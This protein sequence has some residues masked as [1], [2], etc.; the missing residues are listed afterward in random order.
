MAEKMKIITDINKIVPRLGG[1][2]E[3][4]G[5][6]AEHHLYLYLY[7][8]GE[9][10]DLV[11][12]D[13][14]K[15]GGIATY[16]KGQQWYIADEP[17]APF[18]KQMP[19]FVEVL[20]HICEQVPGV[21][22]EDWT[23]NLIKECKNAL[24]PL[25]YHMSRPSSVQYC[26]IVNLEKFDTSFSGK[27]YKGHRYARNHFSKNYTVEFKDASKIPRD[28]L[29]KLIETWSRKRTAQDKVW[30]PDYIKF[31]KNDFP[32]CDIKR[33]LF[34]DGILRGL[35][36]GWRIPNSKGYYIYMDI[37]DYSDAYLGEFV[38]IDHIIEAKMLGYK[39]L[40]FGGSDKNLLH[41][42]KKFHPEAVYTMCNFSVRKIKSG[43]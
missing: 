9:E 33:A 27:K 12:F 22:V 29:I 10:Y 20:K 5:H 25:P 23:E 38:S 28:S 2:I 30:G 37:H 15:D 43:L 11:Y 21:F 32:G 34:L 36:V 1:H 16:K 6:T 42:K 40:D 14:G 26:P 4:F 7:S 19:L 35:S 41:F 8:I 3:K 24:A 13:F 31:I 39:Y 18:Q 17:L